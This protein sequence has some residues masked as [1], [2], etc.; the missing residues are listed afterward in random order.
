MDDAEDESRSG[1]EPRDVGPVQGPHWS[2]RLLQWIVAA[3]CVA[4][5]VVGFWLF[6][7]VLGVPL[8]AIYLGGMVGLIILLPV[9]H[10]I[11][12]MRGR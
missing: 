11:V 8:N 1:Q 4:V 2:L 12:R 7:A 10:F 6:Y 3:F 9:I 5:V